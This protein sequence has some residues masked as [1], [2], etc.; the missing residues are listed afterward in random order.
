MNAVDRFL[1]RLLTLAAVI[2]LGA[3]ICS[4]GGCAVERYCDDH[5][6]VCATVAAGAVF[7][8]AVLV[9]RAVHPPGVQVHQLP[10]SAPI[11]VPC[12]TCAQ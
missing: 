9:V 3:L 11:T 4:Q 10:P 12:A 5:P 7:G 8:C 2:C 1:S 6:G